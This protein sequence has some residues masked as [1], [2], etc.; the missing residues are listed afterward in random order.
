MPLFNWVFGAAAGRGT[1]VCPRFAHKCF[2][3]CV[4]QSVCNSVQVIIE[5]VSVGIESHRC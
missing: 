5:E 3:L 4:I 1:T 2:G